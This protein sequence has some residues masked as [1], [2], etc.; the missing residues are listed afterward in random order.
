MAE[1]AYSDATSYV[2]VKRYFKR[3]KGT[4]P[5][6]GERK[7]YKVYLDWGIGVIDDGAYGMYTYGSPY[8]LFSNNAN[9]IYGDSI[10]DSRIWVEEEELPLSSLTGATRPLVVGD[11][12]FEN[13]NI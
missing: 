12:H 8:S 13:P 7:T 5:K 11:I 4:D 3:V 9:S 10:K 6:T 1:A 2:K